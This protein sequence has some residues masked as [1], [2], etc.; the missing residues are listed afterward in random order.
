MVTN[1]IKRNE[2]LEELK[3]DWESMEQ[4]VDMKDFH[5]ASM[6]QTRI[7]TLIELLETHDCGS[8]GGFDEGQVNRTLEGRYEW[9]INKNL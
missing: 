7:E 4:W 8:I 3:S 6:Y 5:R 9:V 1:T 2:I